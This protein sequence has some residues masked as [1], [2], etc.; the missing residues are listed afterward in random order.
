MCLCPAPDETGHLGRP[1]RGPGSVSVV[2]S[3][4]A[5]HRASPDSPSARPTAPCPGYPP[6]GGAAGDTPRPF[7]EGPPGPGLLP[8]YRLLFWRSCAVLRLVFFQKGGSW[9]FFADIFRYGWRCVSFG[10]PSGWGWLSGD[11]PRVS[12]GRVW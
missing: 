7:S 3:G 12:G 2:R 6:P 1:A 11:M 8:G 5:G 4:A 9:V 10:I